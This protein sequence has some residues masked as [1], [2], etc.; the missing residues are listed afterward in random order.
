MTKTSSTPGCKILTTRVG[1]AAV[2]GFGAP[3][4]NARQDP[5]PPPTEMAKLIS[6]V[7]DWDVKFESREGPTDA[8]TVLHTTS[9]ITQTLSGAFLQERLSMPTPSGVRIELIGIWGYDRF[10]SIYRFAWLDDTYALFDVHEG[11]WE[12]ESLV[13]SNTRTR[14]TLLIGGREVFGR[15]IWSSIGPNGFTVESSAST[16]GGMT[17]FTQAKGRYTRRK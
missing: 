2:L 9:H 4:Y 10:R 3:G 14:T 15:M 17:W 11:N 16:D 12:G 13:V 1:L 7:G 8:F 5:K 6:L